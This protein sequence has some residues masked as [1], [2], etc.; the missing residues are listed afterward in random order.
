MSY[1]LYSA[2]VLA[3]GT[4]LLYWGRHRRRRTA[5]STPTLRDSGIPMALSRRKRDY[6]SVGITWKFDATPCAM[7][8]ELADQRF[9]LAEAPPLPLPDCPQKRCTCYYER[10]SDRREDGSRRAIHGLHEAV[11]RQS[12]V[13]DRR[14]RRDRRRHDS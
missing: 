11:C 1:L 10:F 14:S 5:G 12:G 13:R 3:A 9:L 2:A 6:R 4:A 7:A 8:Q